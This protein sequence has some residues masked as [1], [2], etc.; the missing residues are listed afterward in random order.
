MSFSQPICHARD[1]RHTK[2]KDEEEGLDSRLFYHNIP[3]TVSFSDVAFSPPYDGEGRSP[4]VKVPS[5]LDPI[6][7]RCGT[8]HFVHCWQAQGHPAETVSCCWINVSINAHTH[9]IVWNESVLRYDWEI[10]PAITSG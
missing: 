7:E 1:V 6:A 5:N 4:G 3:T 8:G 9:T 10:M 2:E